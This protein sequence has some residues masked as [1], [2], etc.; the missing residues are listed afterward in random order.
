MYRFVEQ[1]RIMNSWCCTKMT[2]NETKI[3]LKNK[4][5]FR[6]LKVKTNATNSFNTCV[7]LHKQYQRHNKSDCMQQTWNKIK[8]KI[9]ISNE[10]IVMYYLQ[11]NK[12]KKGKQRKRETIAKINGQDKMRCLTNSVHLSCH[13]KI[14]FGWPSR[15]FLPRNI[16][17]HK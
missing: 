4:I 13:S 11:V 1:N 17:K 2:D 6:Y 12:S 15:P 5:S 8:N 14:I 10:T 3:I 9:K 7:H 16:S